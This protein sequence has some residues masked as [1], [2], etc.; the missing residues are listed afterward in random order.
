MSKGGRKV[1]EGIFILRGITLH[2]LSPKLVGLKN[3]KQSNSER[4]A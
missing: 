3:G 2:L 4:A 1:Q